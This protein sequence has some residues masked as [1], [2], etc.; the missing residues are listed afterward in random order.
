MD[1][2]GFLVL[3]LM[4]AGLIWAVLLA[5]AFGTHH[6]LKKN[7]DSSKPKVTGN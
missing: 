2:I 6:D 5:A 1:I 7:S 3:A 4:F